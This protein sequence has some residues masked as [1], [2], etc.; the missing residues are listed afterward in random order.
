MNITIKVDLDNAAFKDNIHELHE[1]LSQQIPHILMPFDF[2]EI[3][4]SNGNTVGN[5]EVDE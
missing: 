4:D 1:I 2:G 5:Y 3:K